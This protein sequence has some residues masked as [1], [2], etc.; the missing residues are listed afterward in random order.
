M[1]KRFLPLIAAV[2]ALFFA[3]CQK[4]G[5]KDYGPDATRGYYPLRGGHY[6]IYDVDSTIFD[7]FTAD[8]VKRHCQVRYTTM[9]TFRDNQNRLS[10]QIMIQKR[11]NETAP[12]TSNDVFYVTPT[13]A[14]IEVVQNNLRI[15]K[16]VFPASNGVVWKG[17]SEVATND[18]D[19]QYFY[20]WDYKYSNFQMPYN[21]GRIEV[22]N[23]VIVDQIDYSFNIPV[24]DTTFAER[25]YGR[26]V[27]GKDIGLVYRE[28]IRWTYD[29]NGATPAIFARKGWAVIMRAVDFN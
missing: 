14:S 2:A 26:E 25:T 8:S 12:W 13:P 3:S 15:R 21:N 11:V 1:S 5:E 29:R 7:D 20:N 17:N 10:Y 9:D 18:I 23:T 19:L 16:L 22:D 4:E 24:K 28:A 6:V 27:Y